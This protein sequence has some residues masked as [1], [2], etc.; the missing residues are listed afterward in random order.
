MEEVFYGLTQLFVFSRIE[1]KKTISLKKTYF[2]VQVELDS[3]KV[4]EKK[5]LK[6]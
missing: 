3:V 1:A 5:L 2:K 4:I 6:N